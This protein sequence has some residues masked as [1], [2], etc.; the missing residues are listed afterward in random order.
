MLKVSLIIFIWRIFGYILVKKEHQL[1]I[2][3]ELNIYSVLQTLA[4]HLD[5]VQ[6]QFYIL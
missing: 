3:Y 4:E 6:K 2:L 1:A 5:K